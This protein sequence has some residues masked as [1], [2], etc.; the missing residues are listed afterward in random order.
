MEQRPC[1]FS[2]PVLRKVLT[3]KR[4]QKGF[5]NPSAGV[6]DNLLG[7]HRFLLHAEGIHD[8]PALMQGTLKQK[9]AVWQR[10]KAKFH[11]PVGRLSA[12]QLI[13]LIY[14]TNKHLKYDYDSALVEHAKKKVVTHACEDSEP[15]DFNSLATADALPT[16]KVH[17]PAPKLALAK[18]KKVNDS[19]L[20]LDFDDRQSFK[21]LT[22]SDIAGLTYHEFRQYINELRANAGKK[23][24]SK[25][26]MSAFW[27]R[28]KD[29]KSKAVKE[30]AHATEM[31]KLKKQEREMQIQEREARKLEKLDKKKA[32]R[33][34]EA[35]ATHERIKA[36]PKIPKKK[37]PPT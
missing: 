30:T 31:R 24:A 37:K 28:A 22:D 34:K 25:Q 19:D 17:K 35:E 16:T 7:E 29:Y 14:A 23:P 12:S 6:L 11:P 15:P 20:D 18:R 13:Q 1:S 2:A 26:Q 4:K 10:I 9:K 27:Q 36:L 8:I 32:A 33:K 5:N 3:Q 21:K